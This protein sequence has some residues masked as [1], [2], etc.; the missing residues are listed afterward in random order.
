MQILIE[1]GADVNA[2]QEKSGETDTE[3]ERRQ[4]EKDGRSP[5]HSAACGGH[6]EIIRLLLTHGA[7]Q[8]LTDI[9]GR[10]PQDAAVNLA[11]KRL[12]SEDDRE[13]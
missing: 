13:K 10:R 1:Y 3:D 8:S 6:A 11:I 9:H 12:F 5:L 4:K 2:V 7:D